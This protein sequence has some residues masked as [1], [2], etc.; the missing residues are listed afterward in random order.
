VDEDSGICETAPRRWMVQSV[1]LVCVFMRLQVL[2]DIGG[3]RQ[4]RGR[5]GARTKAQGQHTATTIR[6]RIVHPRPS[7]DCQ[8]CPFAVID[9]HMQ[10][11]TYTSRFY[12]RPVKPGISFKQLVGRHTRGNTRL[13]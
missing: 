7:L 5:T 2:R 6:L 12:M 13:L 1:R 8:R 9:W 4:V 10:A 3:E 11:G